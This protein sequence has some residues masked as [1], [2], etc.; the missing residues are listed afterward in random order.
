MRLLEAGD[1]QAG[2]RKKTS[3][4]RNLRTLASHESRLFSKHGSA[5][6]IVS[7]SAI[8]AGRVRTCGLASAYSEHLYFPLALLTFFASFLFLRIPI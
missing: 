8:L 5:P 3:A 6:N 7:S 4:R 2:E 1:V